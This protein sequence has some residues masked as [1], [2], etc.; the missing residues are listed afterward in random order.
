MKEDAQKEK[1]LCLPLLVKNTS[2]FDLSLLIF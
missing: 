1:T 2:A